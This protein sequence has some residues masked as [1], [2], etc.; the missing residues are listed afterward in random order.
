MGDFVRNVVGPLVLPEM[1][2]C[3]RL[4]LLHRPNRR[5]SRRSRRLRRRHS[6]GCH[7]KQHSRQLHRRRPPHSTSH[8][9]RRVGVIRC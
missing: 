2:E 5:R 7:N 3:R 9:R 6:Q 4:H 1:V 8:R